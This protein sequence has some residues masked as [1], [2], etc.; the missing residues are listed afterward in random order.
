M[1]FQDLQFIPYK[2]A[3]KAADTDLIVCD[4]YYPRGLNLV[5]LY[6][7]RVPEQYRSNTST[8]AVF[9]WLIDQS[10]S[11][12][13]NLATVVTCNHW[14]IDGFLSLWVALHP[15]L[16]LQYQDVLIAAAHLGDFREFDSTSILGLEA[17]KICA[18]LNAIEAEK[19]CLPFGDL[20]DATIEYEISEKKFE[21][22]LPKF[23]EWLINLD[24]YES[25]WR[26]E[27]DKVL[28]DLAAIDNGTV[29]IIEYPEAGISFVRSE[30]PLH[31]YA[32]FSRVNGGAVI[33]EL[34]KPHYLEFEYRYETIVGRIDKE[35]ITRKDL[36]S[37]ATALTTQ[38]L[39][40]NVRWVFDNINE[41]GTMLRPEFASRPLTREER[42]QSMCYRNEILPET[43]ISAEQLIAMLLEIFLSKKEKEQTP[44]AYAP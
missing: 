12:P 36:S 40:P 30:I 9:K 33:T 35:A 42:Y 26:T 8:E 31:Y 13:G 41:G 14:D 17:L 32:V 16:A 20:E 19:F 37:I 43:S 34:A 28:T 22:F 1:K 27:W 3:H 11:K 18:L 44:I 5:H 21:Y 24:S 4:C 23:E 2:D 29:E 38:E 6:S 25:L 39:T 10:P 7:D 15:E